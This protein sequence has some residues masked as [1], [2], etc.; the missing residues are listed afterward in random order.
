M[1]AD[2]RRSST[3]NAEKVTQEEDLSQNECR[4]LINE[5]MDRFCQKGILYSQHEA[6]DSGSLAVTLLNY[7]HDLSGLKAMPAGSFERIKLRNVGGEKGSKTHFVCK[8]QGC[9]R[10][11]SKSTSLIVHYLRHIN[12]RP[13]SCNFCGRTFT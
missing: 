12:V 2:L 13:Y 8:Y 9:N 3:E 4:Q 11:L 6:R 5:Q 10:V 1:Y 7:R